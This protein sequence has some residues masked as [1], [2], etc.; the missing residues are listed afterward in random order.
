MKACML[1]K[2]RPVLERPLRLEEV[3]IPLPGSGE[4][5]IKVRVCAE[6]RTD[7]HVVE[8]E[9]AVRKSPLIPG[10]QIVGQVVKHGQGVANW[11]QGDRVGVA[12]LHS[13]CGMCSYCQHKRENLCDNARFTGWTNHGGYGSR[14]TPDI[15]NQAL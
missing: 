1:Y 2:P 4:V 15:G 9:L 8:G 12:W 13:T 6:C 11:R 10:H 7:L 5:L 3:D 14:P